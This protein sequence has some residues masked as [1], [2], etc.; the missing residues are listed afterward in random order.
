MAEPP[1]NGGE[2]PGPISQ[3]S[4]ITAPGGSADASAAAAAAVPQVALAAP[5]AAVSA[6]AAH[7]AL[8]EFAASAKAGSLP[9]GLDAPLAEELEAIIREVARTGAT[10]G[11]SWDAL[12]RLLAH[13]MELVLGDFWRDVP[14]LQLQ[15]GE[16]FER[17]AVEPL[18]RSLLELRRDGAPFTVQRM[19][20]LLAEPRGVYKSTRKYLYALQRAVLV[21]STEEALAIQTPATGF[22][23][24]AFAT[25]GATVGDGSSLDPPANRKR[26]LPPE[27]ANGVVAE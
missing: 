9:S 2:G 14:D 26:K 16:S 3:D 7:S 20:E 25:P 4:V 24:A 19:C 11:Y 12:R 21:T 27:L 17:S 1:P 8:L 15:E 18:T 10:N 13:K 5:T 22:S 23:A 6:A